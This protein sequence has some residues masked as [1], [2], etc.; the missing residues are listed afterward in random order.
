M[1]E[2]EEQ[3]QVKILFIFN[4]YFI[5]IFDSGKLVGI[6]IPYLILNFTIRKRN[7]GGKPDR[8]KKILLEKSFISL[9]SYYNLPK[10]KAM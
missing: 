2:Q 8:W 9:S 6:S 5:R 3:K 10:I 4:Q 7:R 1:C